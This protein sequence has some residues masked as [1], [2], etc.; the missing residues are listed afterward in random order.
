MKKKGF[1]YHGETR[2]LDDSARSQAPGDFVK[3]ADGVTHYDLAGP[4]D[5]QTVVLVH[6]FSAP[7]TIWNPTFTALTADGFRVLRFD[8]YGRGFSDRP[9]AAYDQD[10][11][12]RQLMNLLEKLQIRKPVDLAGLSMGGAVSVVFAD[13]HPEWVR[14]LVL[15]D[16]AG[17]PMKKLGL[18]RWLA[19]HTPLVDW[20]MGML[21]VNDFTAKV[22]RWFATKK[23]YAEL[24]DDF[25]SQVQFRGFK[26]A[27][28]S[29]L[30]SGVVSGAED[31]YRSVGERGTPALLLW[32]RKDR[33]VPFRMN[34][35]VR[36][37]IPGVEFH[38]IDDA[39]HASHYDQP[40]I[41]TPLLLEFL[42]R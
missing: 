40:Q 7:Y 28:L 41:A 11:Y 33:T 18:A 10:F 14:R 26:N 38:A 5:A 17:L 42:G 3:L 2:V 19:D 22:G 36:E 4:D 27:L 8:L 13:R 39:G 35:R 25:I 30:R 31:A 32:G 1:I 20:L 24:V 6:G 16:P 21:V 15:V 12:D 37:L 23:G 9:D 29:T 34:R